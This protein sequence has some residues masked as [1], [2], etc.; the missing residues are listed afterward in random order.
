MSRDV[1]AVVQKGDHAVCYYDLEGEELARVALDPYPHEWAVSP[2]RS[3]AYISHFGLALAEDEGPGGNTVSV[4]DLPN[5]R[6]LGVLDCGEYRRPHG[7]T[8]DGRG[9]LYVLSEAGNRLLIADEPST[10]RF[11][12]DLPS[13]GEGSHIVTVSRD[14]NTAFI[15]NMRSHTV[16]VVFPEDPDYLPVELDSGRRPEGSVLDRDQERLYVACRESAQI[17]VVDAVSLQVLAPIPTRP[18]PVRLC[19]DHRQRLL[20]P[21]Y[22]DHSLALIDPGSRH[23]DYIRLPASPVSVGFDADSGLALVSTLGDEVCVI[24][25]EARSLDRR[26]STR[27]DPDPALLL[28]LPD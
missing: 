27:A 10:G 9:S 16:S 13:G 3:R 22:H 1:I 21:L 12:R 18:G 25:V 7:I 17:M 26:I 15:S 8:L 28:Q 23:I 6:K 24:D 14:G 5:R 19:W 2:D 20:A 4:L 11:D